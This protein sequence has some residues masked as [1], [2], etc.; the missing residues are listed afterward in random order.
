MEP[1]IP[2]TT[3][4]F[5]IRQPTSFGTGRACRAADL[6]W[7]G[8]FAA[9]LATLASGCDTSPPPA[10]AP[11]STADILIGGAEAKL[12]PAE[13]DFCLDATP[14]MEGF[15]AAPDSVYLRFLEDL[16]GSLLAGLEAGGAVR[17]CKFG[18]AIR[19][20]ERSEFRQARFPAFYREPGIFK[21]TNL[22]LLLEKRPAEPA[23]GVVVAVT[24]LFQKDQDLNLVVRQIKEGCLSRPDCSVG[25]LALPSAFDGMVHDSK[26]GSYHYR[27]TA[28]PASLRPFY[29]LMFGQEARILQLSEVLSAKSYVNLDHLLVIG[30]RTV[31]SF[32]AT[33]G[34]NPADKGVSPKKVAAGGGE[35]DSAF[36]LRKGF[37]EARLTAQVKV[38]VDRRAFGFDPT[39]VALRAFRQESGQMKPAEGEMKLE[40]LV[41]SGETMQ[42]ELTL[43]PPATRGDYFYVGELQMGNINGGRA[44]G[45]IAQF[46]SENPGPHADAAKTLNLDRLV[47]GLLA[48]LLQEKE[49]RPILARFRIHLRRL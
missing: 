2:H 7:H 40:S 36:N 32:Q 19:Q 9:A 4:R 38:E 48:A 1:S 23:G 31:A 28:D 35:L 27:S 10:L 41:G 17:Y 45:W 33:L 3:G 49:K 8:L 20:I 22:E 34:R 37:D 30:P 24:D 43:T 14:S 25:L 39:K 12:P 18:A 46:S 21:D 13:I 6:L 29:L 47:E 16:E 42:L 26:A 44:P 5:M 11:L 15:A